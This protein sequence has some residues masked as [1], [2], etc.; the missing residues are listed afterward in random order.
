M[1]QLVLVGNLWWICPVYASN[2]FT[3]PFTLAAGLW[4]AGFIDQRAGSSTRRRAIAVI[5]CALVLPVM[6]ALVLNTNAGWFSAPRLMASDLDKHPR[7]AVS[8]YRYGSALIQAG[9]YQR[10]TYWL[11]EALDQYPKS[12]AARQK[13]ALASYLQGDFEMARQQYQM[14]LE[15]DPHHLPALL[16][17][18][19]LAVN[20]KELDRAKQHL[21]TAKSIAPF[22]SEVMFYSAQMAQQRGDTQQALRQYEALLS[23][24]PDHLSGQRDYKTLKTQQRP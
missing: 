9:R 2:L 14:V 20:Q 3:L 11:N 4:L 23:K 10:A 13:V 1:G 5:P 7:N 18:V 15:I 8:M 19:D 12:I 24:Y 17:L 22:D 6:G 21:D 16:K